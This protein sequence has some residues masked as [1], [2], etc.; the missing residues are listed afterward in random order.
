MDTK[1][2]E[3]IID[4]KKANDGIPPSVREMCAFLERGLPSVHARLKKLEEAGAIERGEGA[5]SIRI[6]GGQWLPPA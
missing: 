2:L 1:L 4:Y 6:P 5:R 3:F